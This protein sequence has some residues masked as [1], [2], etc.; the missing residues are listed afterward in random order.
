MAKK[1]DKD[2]FSGTLGVVVAISLICSVVVAGAAVGLKPTQDEQ[3]L[4]DK[5]RNILSV[6]GLLEKNTDV[7][8]VYAERIEPRVIDLASGEYVE[9][10]DFDARTAVQDPAQRI[11]INP[12]DDY[13]GLKVR[14]KY[15]DVYLVKGGDGNVNQVI[16]P[17]HGNGL[18]SVMY[19]FVAVQPDGNTLN[20]I[21]YYQQGETAGLG[22]EIANPLWQAQFNG[23]KLYDEQGNVAIR[24]AK[25]GSADKEHGVDALSGASLTSKGV[26]GSFSYWFGQNGFAPY[27]AKLKAEGVK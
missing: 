16:L 26:Q 3:K 24:I 25:G 15:A 19:A 8:A 7:K 20:G 13:A 9:A 14:P 11:N 23:K 1:F 10:P 4:L 2:S 5:Q 22:G 18:W 6:A 21:T 12:E 17:M 27:L